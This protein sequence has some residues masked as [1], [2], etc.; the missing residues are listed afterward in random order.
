MRA[1]YLKDLEIHENYILKGDALHHLV[2]VVRI[3]EGDELLLLNGKGLKV[4]TFVESLSK[5]E[6]KLKLHQHQTVGREYNFD[7]ALGIPKRE[8][9]ELCLKQATELGFRRIYL[10]RSD[11]SQMRAPEADR[12]EKLL[13]SA[14]EQSNAG[15]LPEIIE[16]DW[17]ELP[18]KE[19]DYSIMLDSQTIPEKTDKS[20]LSSGSHL[21]IIGPEGG[22]SGGELAFLHGQEKLKVVNLPT[23]ILRTPTALA[24]G[25]GMMIESLRK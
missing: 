7:V 15:F 21:L 19:Y 11:Y 2:N 17:K 8:A 5:K 12:M 22:F 13:I 14:L 4:T 23:P 9:L 1:S 16:A 24:A 20:T 25:A 18:W 3:K 6:L 10:I